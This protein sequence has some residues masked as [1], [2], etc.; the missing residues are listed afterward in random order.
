MN[1]YNIDPIELKKLCDDYDK[2]YETY[3]ESEYEG[4][5]IYEF[6]MEALNEKN[7]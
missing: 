7:I 3:R 2:E 5:A 6:F 1:K 4:K